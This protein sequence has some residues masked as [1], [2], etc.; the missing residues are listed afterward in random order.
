MA[1]IP[2]TN[3]AT[4]NTILASDIT[5]IINSLDGTGSYTVIA[6]GSFSGSFTGLANSASYASTASFVITAQTASYVVTAQTA[7]YVTLAQTASYVT[8]A[9]TASYVTLAQTA[10]FV[11]TAQTASYVTLAQTAS[12]VTTAQTASYVTLAQT[13][14]FVANAQTASLATN[15]PFTGITSL[16]ASLSGSNGGGVSAVRPALTA[17]SYTASID[18]ITYNGAFFPIDAQAGAVNIL[19][20]DLGGSSKIGTEFVFF[21]TDAT[22]DITFSSVTGTTTIICSGSLST[23]K[24]AGTGLAVVAKFIERSGVPYKWAVIGGIKA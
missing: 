15:I 4:G 10:S 11:T 12:Y 20:D 14:S 21:A 9:Q 23:P 6:T 1:L 7:S 19:L 18:L 16:P 2:K 17:V 3:I 13:A 8:T 5:N 24:I 22:N